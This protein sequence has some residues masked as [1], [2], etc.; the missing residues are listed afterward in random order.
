MEE[1]GKTTSYSDRYHLTVESFDVVDENK[2]GINEPGE[3]I[4]VRNIVVKNEGE[5]SFYEA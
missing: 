5:S 2:D 1:D 4:F 3:Y